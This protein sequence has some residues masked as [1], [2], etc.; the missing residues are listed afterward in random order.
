M[1]AY[2]DAATFLHRLSQWV[3]RGHDVP[4]NCI[5]PIVCHKIQTLDGVRVLDFLPTESLGATRRI[6]ESV[7]ISLGAAVRAQFDQVKRMILAHELMRRDSASTDFDRPLPGHPRCLL[8][9]LP[10]HPSGIE[11][12]RG[13][14]G[15]VSW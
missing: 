1:L 15:T 13:W 11:K 2:L 14:N 12:R 3:A 10:C 5:E 6:F 8:S 7:A 4:A 9:S